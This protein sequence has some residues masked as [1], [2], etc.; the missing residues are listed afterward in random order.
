M[1]SIH[2]PWLCPRDLSSDAGT[3]KPRSSATPESR[4]GGSLPWTVADCWCSQGLICELKFLLPNFQSMVDLQRVNHTGS[5]GT[6]GV[7]SHACKSNW[8]F[9]IFVSFSVVTFYPLS[10][11]HFPVTSLLFKAF[12]L[13]LYTFI[14][15]RYIYKCNDLCNFDFLID[16]TCLMWFN[17]QPPVMQKVF[18]W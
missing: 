7:Q 9:C 8:H 16:F 17:N 18:N 11:G 15:F 13:L 1:K 5:Q 4:R 3:G 12:F 2:R 10:Y 14:Y 6:F